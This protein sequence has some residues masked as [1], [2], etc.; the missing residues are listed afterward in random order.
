MIN[1]F[2]G[3]YNWLS[4]MASCKPFIVQG[5]TYNSVENF[6]QASKTTNVGVKLKMSKMNPFTS[7][8]YGQAITKR[9][10]WELI[11]DE[12]MLFGLKEKFSQPRYKNL[13]INTGTKD[14]IE[15][16]FHNDTYWGVNIE[17]GKGKNKLGNMIMDIRISIFEALEKDV[18]FIDQYSNIQKLLSLFNHKDHD[19][20]I[21]K[22]LQNKFFLLEPKFA[23]LDEEVGKLSDEE[24]INIVDGNTDIVA[25]SSRLLQLVTEYPKF[26][27]KHN[28]VEVF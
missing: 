20:I 24:L 14:L 1:R 2:K 19:K 15:G 4:N 6:Y 10:D 28:F 27:I 23:L 3:E 22:W 7:R 12:I 16:N 21:I 8:E 26:L 5:V 17:S 11:K 18:Y 9:S 25:I 13:L